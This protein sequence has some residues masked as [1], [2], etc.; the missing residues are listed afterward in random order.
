MLHCVTALDLKSTIE[1]EV[2]TTDKL[3]AKTLRK[4]KAKV[5]WKK[6][7]LYGVEFE[8]PAKSL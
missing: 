6:N 7:Q 4:F 5:V 8:K 3:G 2:T 1:I